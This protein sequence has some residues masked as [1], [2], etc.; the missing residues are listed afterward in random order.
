MDQLEKLK[1]EEAELEAQMLG[2]PTEPVATTEVEEGVQQS[3]EELEAADYMEGVITGEE[4]SKE[5]TVSSPSD[6]PEPQKPQRINW[7]KRF[8]NFKASADA[9]IYEQRQ[10]IANLKNNVATLMGELGDL[11]EAKR[12]VQGDMF[13][14]AFSQEDE[15]TFGAD[16][17]AVVK[18]AAQV[19]I[20][21][22]VK[23]LKE[24]LRKQEVARIDDAK[25]AANTE[26]Q[27]A[28][29]G[30]L[31]SLSNLVPDYAAINTDPKFMD[32]MKQ[33]DQFSGLPKSK[34]FVQAEQAR[35]VA[36]VAD[37]F[38]EYKNERDAKVQPNKPKD[39]ERHVTPM[40]GGGAPSSSANQKEQV[41]YYR[42]SDI[43]KFYR[44]VMKG[45]YKG[46]QGVI[47]ATESAIELAV[48]ENR[49]L[50]GQ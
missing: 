26:R 18:K 24:Q 5:T 28:Y 22:Q 20:E 35:D 1:Q 48:R 15:D 43:D 27:T 8:T 9:S 14:G 32:W 47:D 41:G 37:F 2:N 31:G 34:L 40:G 45:R 46:N 11:R 3:Q 25:R 16:G 42:Q 19:A 17:M 4:E 6:Q 13:E 50:K 7:K 23:P 12:E 36:R 30:F 49:V 10:E 38:I 39:L 44:D 21:S 29:N 33:P